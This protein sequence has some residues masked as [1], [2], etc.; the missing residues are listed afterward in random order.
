MEQNDVIEAKKREKNELEILASIS[1]RD[2]LKKWKKA[3][4]IIAAVFMPIAALALA[5]V[6]GMLVKFLESP[7]NMLGSNADSFYT[8]LLC[9]IIGIFAVL[10]IAIAFRLMTSAAAKRK[11][12]ALEASIFLLNADIESAAMAETVEKEKAEAERKKAEAEEQR[13]EIADEQKR[14]PGRPKKDQ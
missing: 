7:A 9:L 10:E 1:E 3:L 4:L 12:E 14:K 11:Q 13:Q 2:R 8:G 5:L 6:R